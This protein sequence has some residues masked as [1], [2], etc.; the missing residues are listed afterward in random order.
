M[1]ES[2]DVSIVIISW[3]MRDL[4]ERCLKTIFNFTKDL[5][6]EIIVVDNNSE[7]GTSEMISEKFPQ[8]KLVKN[9][10]NR[11]VAPARNQ[12]IKETTGKYILILDADMELVENSIKQLFDFM[13]RTD[14]CGIVG[15]KLVDQ[16]RQLQFSCKRFPTLLA[17]L[18]RRLEW[19]ESIKNSSTLR[20]HTMQDWDHN[21]IKQVDY[22]IGA[23]QFFRRDV[24]EKIGLYDDNIFYGPEDIDFC[25]R[26]WKAGWKVYYYPLTQIIHHEQRI[27]KKNLFSKISLKHFAGIFYLYRKYNFRIKV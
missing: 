26:A 23:C 21:E 19:I 27:T 7:D 16:N 24:I 15:C 6:F 20:N 13:E 14:D 8:I 18:F 11:G 4:L 17:F 12:G 1:A 3:K 9:S 2:I 5:S 10:E 22:L 25:L